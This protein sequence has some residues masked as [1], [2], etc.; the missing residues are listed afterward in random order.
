MG[1]RAIRECSAYGAAVCVFWAG[2]R[3]YEYLWSRNKKSL[4]TL[5][6]ALEERRAAFARGEF[7]VEVSRYQCDRCVVRAGCPAWMG[8]GSILSTAWR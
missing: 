7:G 6:G 5:A 2:W 1:V 4:P 3:I 8:A